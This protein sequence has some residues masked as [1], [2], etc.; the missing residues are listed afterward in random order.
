M[1]DQEVRIGVYICHCGSNIAG[2]LDVK[3]LVQC[4]KKLP[5]VVA[6]KDYI[7]MCSE[8]GQNMIAEDIKK[9][10]T[11]IEVET[12]QDQED[13]EIIQD[14]QQKEAGSEM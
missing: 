11:I 5:S 7:Y 2:T 6:A 9:D 14:N 12:L 13:T 4:A 10:D 1:E 8:P 3:E